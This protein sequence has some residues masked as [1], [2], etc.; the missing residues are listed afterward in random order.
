MPPN[1]LSLKGCREPK[2]VEKHWPGALIGTLIVISHC[3][4]PTG[5]VHCDYLTNFKHKS[6][7]RRTDPLVELTTFFEKVKYC[8]GFFL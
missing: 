2:Q 1:F 8:I 7:R 4:V 5:E 3:I 6:K